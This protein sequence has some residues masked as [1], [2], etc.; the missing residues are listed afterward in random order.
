MEGRVYVITKQRA[1]SHFRSFILFS[2]KIQRRKNNV[3]LHIVE[4]QPQKLV[5]NR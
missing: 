1:K 4:K 2:L 3:F 5:S